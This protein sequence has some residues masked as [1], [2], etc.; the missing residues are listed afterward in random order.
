VTKD[1]RPGAR[2]EAVA[3]A[4]LASTWN[5]FVPIDLAEV[6]PRS[7][8]PIPPVKGTS[9]QTGRWDIAGNARVVHL[10]D[11]TSVREEITLSDPSDGH[12]PSDGRAR[13]GYRVSGFTGPMARLAREARGEWLFE[14]IAPDRTRIVWTY[15]FEP[16][17]PLA[18]LPLSLVVATFWKAYMK[19]GL[20][21]VRRAAER[22]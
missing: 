12:P 11:G 13:F 4:S 10:G 1:N 18:R 22:G 14:E 15:A 19:D 16:A 2:V 9:G 6:F 8:G 5:V 17:S 3:Q 20:E 7:K 21:N